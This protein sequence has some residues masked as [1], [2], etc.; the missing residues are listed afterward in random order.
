MPN[1][2]VN[3]LKNILGVIPMNN[4]RKINMESKTFVA[5]K[6]NL[7]LDGADNLYLAVT[8]RSSGGLTFVYTLVSARD[9][10][11]RYP[12]IPETTVATFK[13]ATKADIYYNTVLEIMRW[14][15]K[16]YLQN[17]RQYFRDNAADFYKHNR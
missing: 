13:N 9:K 16:S 10:M 7:Q 15:S 5:P 3:L 11:N 8:R 1:S 17:I 2:N 6:P 14:Q 4:A 12:I